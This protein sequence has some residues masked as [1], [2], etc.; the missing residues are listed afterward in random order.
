MSNIKPE[1]FTLTFAKKVNKY[2]QKRKC[3]QGPLQIFNINHDNIT[4]KYIRTPERI[5]NII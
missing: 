4:T 2:K 5:L 3:K 1:T